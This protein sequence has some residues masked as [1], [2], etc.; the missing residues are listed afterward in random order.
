MVNC[1]TDHG[2]ALYAELIRA[3]TSQPCDAVAAHLSPAIGAAA[4]TVPAAAQAGA[5][6]SAAASAATATAGSSPRVQQHEQQQHYQQ[7]RQSR[8]L[9]WHV[10][11]HTGSSTAGRTSMCSGASTS[12]GAM[13]EQDAGVCAICCD[14]QVGAVVGPCRH[15]LCCRCAL[16]IVDPDGDWNS[17]PSC[18]FCR[19]VIASFTGTLQS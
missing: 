19:G 12:L 3:G 18:P 10:R 9:G 13:G 14:A 5:A 1:N 7:R 4:A 15:R 17:P 2:G 11:A 16:H 8:V 6:A